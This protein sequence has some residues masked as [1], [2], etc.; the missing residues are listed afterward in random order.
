[1]NCLMN[2]Q[3]TCPMH[4]LSTMRQTNELPL[5][6]QKVGQQTTTY[7]DS[8]L[9]RMEELDEELLKTSTTLYSVPGLTDLEANCD[10]ESNVQVPSIPFTPSKLVADSPALKR[11]QQERKAGNS[12]LLQCKRKLFTE[13][14]P[15]TIGKCRKQH[16]PEATANNASECLPNELE[17]GGG[18]D[19]ASD[20][21]NVTSS[22]HNPSIQNSSTSHQIDSTSPNIAIKY[23]LMRTP[24]KIHQLTQT[25][26][27]LSP[28]KRIVRTPQPAS[29]RNDIFDSLNEIPTNLNNYYYIPNET[30]TGGKALKASTVLGRFLQ[31]SQ[32]ND[33]NETSTKENQ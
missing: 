17:I 8:I 21:G 24:K 13:H 29:K 12:P 22:A 4:A 16:K 9:E 25:P 20:I 31:E 3:L 32:E 33:Q 5:G 23:S 1:M 6:I 26:L 10:D 19:S 7:C 2:N 30:L 15:E 18:F 11:I 14:E 28:V 27:I